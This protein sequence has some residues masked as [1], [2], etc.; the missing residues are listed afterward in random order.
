MATAN[1]NVN[2]QSVLQ[3]LTSGQE[4]PFVIPEYQRP[5]SWSDDEI[6]TLFED[7][8]EFSI[9][10]THNDGAKSYFLGCIVSYEE[11]GER[12]IIDGQQRITSLFLLLRAVFYMLEKEDNKTDEVRNFIQ[13]IKPALWK[14]NEMTGKED[15]S[16]ILLRSE[17]VTDNGNRILQNILETGETVKNAKDNY[18]RNYNKFKELYE[19]KSQNSPNQIYHFVLALLNYSILLPITADDQETALTIFNTLNN[20]GLPLSDADIFKSYIYKKLDDSEKKKFINKWKKLETDAEKANESI[21][22]LFYYNMFYMRAKEKDDKSTTPGVRKYYLNKNSNRLTP[23]VIDD[24]AINL[25]LWK[26]INNREP[27]EDEEWSLNMDI[28]KILD[29]LSSY[30]NEFWKYPVSIFFMEH[31]NKSNFEEQF[32]IFLRKLYV[33]LLTRYLEVPTINAVKT[34]ILKLNVQII[35]NSHPEFYAGFGVNKP[36]D[37]C[38]VDIEKTRTDKLIITPHKNMVRMLLKLLAYQED[39]QSDLLPVYWEI[40]H[41]FPQSWDTKYYTLDEE[42]T[43]EKLEHLGNKLPL[44]KKL[45]ISASNNYFAK[46]KEKYRNSKIAIVKRLGESPLNEWDLTN[47]DENDIKVCN[48]VKHILKTWVDEYEKIEDTSKIPEATPEELEM[49]RMLKEKGLI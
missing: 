11:D 48:I 3:L 41:I 15:R 6:I 8:W 39:T 14:E 17:V 19:Q 44:E 38:A 18:S 2:K 25:Q 35:K 7:L 20:R 12:Q 9:E 47:I 5:Y 23:E 42:E 1:I 21:Q 26:V 46:K 30:T 32:L 10:R 28:R 22:S 37:R 40:E 49:I 45:N 4:I 13:K 16:Q 24:L 33:M 36:E 29:C 31:K 34:D 43:N 27:V